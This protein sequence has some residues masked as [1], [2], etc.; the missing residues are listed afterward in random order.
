MPQD[1]GQIPKAPGNPPGGPNSGSPQ[2]WGKEVVN[3]G[4]KVAKGGAL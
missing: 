4:E 2:K 1:R 3:C